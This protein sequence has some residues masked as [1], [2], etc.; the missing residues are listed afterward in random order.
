MNGETGEV[1]I[2]S[3]IHLKEEWPTVRKVIINT[4]ISE[5]VEVGIE[6]ALHGLAAFQEL[7]RE[8]SLAG[9]TLRSVTVD[10]DKV[11]RALPVAARAETNMVKLV[12]G[13]WVSGFLDEATSFPHGRHDDRVDSVSGAFQMLAQPKFEFVC[14]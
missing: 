6:N 9:V 5:G 11:S 2:S 8:E 13:E 14:L 3:M 12:I 7:Q 1:F 4:A 10:K